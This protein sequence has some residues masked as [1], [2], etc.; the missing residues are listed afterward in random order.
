[1]A[2]VSA[3]LA[4][5]SG[6]TASRGGLG[7]RPPRAAFG[8]R[9]ALAPSAPLG[10]RAG[11]LGR[12]AAAG[13]RTPGGSCRRR[14]RRPGR[15]RQPAC[16]SRCPGAGSRRL[17]GDAP[18]CPPGGG[19]ATAALTGPELVDLGS[20][21]V[22]LG[23]KVGDLVAQAGGG[24]TTHLRGAPERARLVRH[25]RG[26]VG[27]PVHAGRSTRRAAV[28]FGRARGGAL[29]GSLAAAGCGHQRSR[30]TVARRACAAAR[31]ATGTRYG[32][33]DT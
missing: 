21:A 30:S 20:E 19:E 17:A 10:A 18:R 11:S 8:T 7:F 31:R 28:R 15:R 27:C 33:H 29:S 16:G 24:L 23:T 4:S 6:A 9:S 12:S 32:E 3:T 25:Q 2:P 14:T 22:N 26:V 5:R 13:R 1:V